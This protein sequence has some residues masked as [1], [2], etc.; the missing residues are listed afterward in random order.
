VKA[1]ARRTPREIYR[2]Y[3]REAFFADA[4]GEPEPA[5][6]VL[7]SAR[8]SP[9]GLRATPTGAAAPVVAI[10][11]IAGATAFV[12]GDL[13]LRGGGA[14]R[15]ADRWRAFPKVARSEV[16][17]SSSPSPGVTLARW[18]SGA[19]TRE[20]ARGRDGRPEAP[21]A[22]GVEP[23]ATSSSAAGSAAPVGEFGFER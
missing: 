5:A 19:W 6:E 21:A 4:T 12:V 1:G 3:E 20:L 23:A 10:V 9:P 11:A 18:H 13:E 22:I 8:R 15:A 7:P 17:R 2:V 14:P 16:A